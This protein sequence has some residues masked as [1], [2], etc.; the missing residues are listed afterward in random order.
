M[1]GLNWDKIFIPSPSTINE[2]REKQRMICNN[3][4]ASKLETNVS[5]FFRLTS[6]WS[7]KN[8]GEIKI[9]LD[10]KQ[11][12]ENKIKFRAIAFLSWKVKEAAWRRQWIWRF[13]CHNFTRKIRKSRNRRQKFLHI[14]GDPD[15]W[16]RR[17]RRCAKS[18]LSVGE[19][20]AASST[21][22]KLCKFYKNWKFKFNRL[23][24]FCGLTYFKGHLKATVSTREKSPMIISEGIRAFHGGLS[25]DIRDPNC[26]SRKG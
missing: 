2:P 10:T 12:M 14:L 19:G 23:I 4:K 5:P 6:H 3:G 21:A 15:V 1:N 16:R 18:S 25:K 17:R 20:K 26:T 22:E 9:S 8:N 24:W 13:A 11:F 7:Q